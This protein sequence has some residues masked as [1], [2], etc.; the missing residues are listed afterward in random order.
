MRRYAI[1]AGIGILVG[2]LLAIASLYFPDEIHEFARNGDLDGIKALV[3][4][5]PE[6]VNAKDKDGRTPLYW[7]CRGVH[8]EVVKFLVEKGADV[9]AEDSNKIVPLHSLATRNAAAAI[10]V[11]LD[12]GANVDAKDYGGGTALHYAASRRPEIKQREDLVRGPV[13]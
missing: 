6:L 12:N 9:N 4:K 2:S 3:E 8:L 1:S 7:A 10:A 5:N 13:R 11:L